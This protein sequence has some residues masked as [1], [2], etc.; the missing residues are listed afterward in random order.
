MCIK[1]WA[2]FGT[3]HPISVCLQNYH[4]WFLTPPQT[5][6]QKDGLSW[7]NSCFLQKDASCFRKMRFPA[8]KCTFLQKDAVFRGHMAEN[9]R[10]LQESFKRLA[11]SL[12]IYLALLLCC[13]FAVSR[14][15]PLFSLLSFFSL[16]ISAIFS[17]LSFLLFLS[18]AISAIFSALLLPVGLLQ[19]W[20]SRVRVRFCRSLVCSKFDSGPFSSC[21]VQACVKLRDPAAILFISRATFS[22]SSAKLFCACFPG[23][24]HKHRAICCK[25]GY[26]IDMSA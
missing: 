5:T 10:N 15:L 13:T 17:L 25:M 24:S 16:A 3:D 26:R 22:D 14:C 8:W 18:L 12:Y 6:L 1:P 2:V 23:V 11:L 19:K 20:D 9:R 4:S 21:E 7:R